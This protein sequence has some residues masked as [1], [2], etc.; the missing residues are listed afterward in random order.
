[1]ER[2]KLLW[3]GDAICETGFGRVTANLLD[4]L[5][6]DL[7]EIAC[8]GVNYNGWPHD[9][10]W[11][12][13]PAA[14][15]LGGGNTDPFGFQAQTV[16]KVVSA[17]RPHLVV[18]FNDL[19]NINGWFSQ[20][21][22]LRE[23]IGF[24]LMAYFPTD[25]TSYFAHAGWL[26]KFDRVATYTEH[27]KQAIL[28]SWVDV[29]IDVIPHGI[30]LGMFY[31]GDRA[32]ARKEL[33]IDPDWFVVLNANRNQPRKRID[34]TIRGFA[35]A[36]HL[37]AGNDRLKLF[38]HMG[39][40]AIGW[41]YE[42]LF[43]AECKRLE[44]DST[45]RIIGVGGD[46]RTHPYVTQD[47]L[48]AIYQAS[49]LVVNTSVGEGWGLISW[50]SGACGIPQIMP[51]H[52]ACEMWGRHA[53]FLPIVAEYDDQASS[54]RHSVPSWE[55]LGAAI[56]QYF[57]DPA[58][59]EEMGQRAIAWTRQPRWSWNTIANQLQQILTE[60]HGK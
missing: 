27:G 1:M 57:H 15:L 16:R 2:I 37:A 20:I 25:G 38:C 39:K 10:T 13:I 5:P 7:F 56:S 44:L 49:N 32:E 9:K 24:K 34:L 41:D 58:L 8:V 59:C 55:A 45:A 28:D 3:V 21:E 35:R 42:S 31:P 17:F 51:K 6:P 46:R 54:V 23:E 53:T 22:D 60:M 33:G 4:R 47:Q 19:W 30:D 52:S 14:S 18:L 12:V 11:Q 40:E 36:L 29:P 50:E 43:N 48:R 26:P